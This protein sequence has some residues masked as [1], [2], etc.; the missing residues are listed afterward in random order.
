V[1]PPW[2]GIEGAAKR[3]K[4]NELII[5]AD[6]PMERE[7]EEPSRFDHS[8]GQLT[9]SRSKGRYSGREKDGRLAQT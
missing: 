8:G 2:R 3:M 5:R 4:A 9:L 6:F 7:L 1:A